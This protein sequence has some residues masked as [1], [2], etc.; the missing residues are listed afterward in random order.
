MPEA[1]LPG[2]EARIRTL[3]EFRHGSSLRDRIRFLARD[4]VIRALSRVPRRRVSN[5]IRFPYYHYVF[6]DERAGFAAQLAYFR[7]AGEFISLDDAVA[8]LGHQ[9][10]DGKYFCITFDD[11]FRNC[12]TNAVPILVDSG[13]TA[14][15]FVPTGFI[16]KS[17]RENPDL[18]RRVSNG[19]EVVPEFLRWKD[20]RLM[21]DAAM[22]IGSHSVNHILLSTSSDTEVERELRESKSMIEREIG[23]PCNHF[24]CPRGRPGVDF[25]SDRDPQIARRLGYKSFLTAQRGSVRRLPDPFLIERDHLLALS[26]THHLRYFFSR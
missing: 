6:D 11:G 22:T 17:P 16:G 3:R 25:K 24:S 8:C 2:A 26:G 9:Q 21:A 1:N 19:G 4:A 23:R 10:V 14:T 7:N 20:C 15:F 18:L 12:L 5:W 13:A